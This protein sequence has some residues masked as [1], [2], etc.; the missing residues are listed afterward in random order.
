M[1]CLPAMQALS[2]KQ[3]LFQ[4]T[5]CKVDVTRLWPEVEADGGLPL[6]CSVVVLEKQHTHTNQRERLL[7]AVRLQLPFLETDQR[8]KGG[9]E[10][11]RPQG[12]LQSQVNTEL[13]S[14]Q[15]SGL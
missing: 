10:M 11:V 15:S 4:T 6:A 8:L 2:K 13:S 7:A 12:H 1:M 9:M 14:Q 3:F 5:F